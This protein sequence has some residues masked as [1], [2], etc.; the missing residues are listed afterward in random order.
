MLYTALFPQVRKEGRFLLVNHF[1]KVPHQCPQMSDIAALFPQVSIMLK[2]NMK[3]MFRNLRIQNKLLFSYSLVFVISMTIGFSLIYYVV[4]LSIEEN[5]ESELQNTTNSILNLVRTSATVS[6]KNYIRGVAEKNH[7]IVGY[8]YNQFINGLMDEDTAK[9]LASE[10]LLSQTI[11][12]TGYIYCLDS[13]GTVVVHPSKP[14]VSVN[15]SEY[16]FVKKMMQRKKGYLEYNW[17]NIEDPNSRAKALYMLH[18]KPWD[19]IISVSSYRS[20]FKELIN[21]YDFKKSVLEL[22]FGETGYSFV[23]DG[24][25]NAVIHPKIQDV[26]ILEAD[27]LPNEFLEDMLRKRSGEMRYLW[28]NPGE[29]KARLKLAIYNYL[30]TYDWIVGS[31]SY[32]EEFYEPLRLIRHLILGI[33]FVTIVVVLL[34]TYTLS[35]S[36]TTPLKALM[37]SFQEASGGDFSSRMATNSK[38]ELGSLSSYFNQFMQ[39]LEAYDS[40]LKKE[41]FERRQVENDLRESEGRYESIMEAAADPIVIY[42]M[43]GDVIYFNPAFENVFGWKLKDCT[44]R[45]I[46][47]FVPKEYDNELLKTLQKLENGDVLSK[48]EAKRYTKEGDIRTVSISGALYKDK[49]EQPAGLVVILRDITERKRLS[50]RLL[51][52]GD[53]VRQE[54]GQDL[55]D[56]LCPHLIGIAGLATVLA[57]NL[58]EKDEKNREL[59]GKIVTF[60]EEAINKSKILARGL[61]PVHLVDHGLHLAISE[62]AS[63]VELTTNVSCILMMDE[64]LN[65]KDNLIAMHLYYIVQEAVNNAVKHANADT[66]EISISQKDD[67]ILHLEIRDNGG[68]IQE[69]ALQ[70]GMGL[71]I[72]KYRVDVIG[73]LMEINTDRE[74]GTLIHISL[75]LPH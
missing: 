73:A 12:E 11:G 15:V 8:F 40:S 30:P 5:I 31:S 49:R 48:I 10:V 43:K 52:I 1:G 9:A 63:R 27:E 71:Q 60:I 16:D 19:W 51:D 20:E 65:V 2:N 44:G 23:L 72:M 42:D 50:K 54:I 68:G 26:N 70:K 38:D 6:I 34:L 17:K 41:I 25:G 28:K 75:K 32:H 37:R 57:G 61:C 7:E 55:H 46:D 33:F 74:R 56:D 18:F 13:A 4:R 58:P 14:L 24:K 67:C 59:A 66:I 64:R 21:V 39:Q 53:T 35:T 3:Q 22:R 45:G 62:I 69:T 29:N 36:I 47:N